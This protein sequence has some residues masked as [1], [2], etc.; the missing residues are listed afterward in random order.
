L[1]ENAVSHD[2]LLNLYGYCILFSLDKWLSNEWSRLGI[3]N[4]VDDDAD[5]HVDYSL[6]S[7]SDYLSSFDNNVESSE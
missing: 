2:A 6:Y 3:S 7:I 5:I 4:A 1:V